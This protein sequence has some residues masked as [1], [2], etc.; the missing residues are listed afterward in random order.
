MENLTAIFFWGFLALY[1]IT[2]TILSPKALTLGLFL[3]AR[4]K[5]VKNLLHLY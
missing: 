2:M 4:T 5:T 1:G 3:R